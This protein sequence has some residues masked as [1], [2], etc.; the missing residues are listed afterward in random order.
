MIREQSALSYMQKFDPRV[1]LIILFFMVLMVLFINQDHKLIYLLVLSITIALISKE[2]NK[3]HIK[4]LLKLN[5]IMLSIFILV[6]I[7]IE[8]KT[9]FYINDIVW[10]YEGLYRSSIIS[11]KAN[12]IF[13][14][15]NIFVI[16]MPLYELGV[17]LHSLMISKK[18]IH[19]LLFMVRYI[20][21]IDEEYNKLTTA[22]KLRGFIPRPS[23]HTLKVYGQIIGILLIRSFERSEKVYNAMRLRGYN[24]NFYILKKLTIR[25]HDYILIIL[26]LIILVPVFI[27]DVV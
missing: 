24:G 2:F 16:N 14:L 12:I 3:A 21:V 10:S 27:W 19:I 23:I 20:N 17:S 8:G 4:R 6:P 22:I 1:R 15:M 13:F 11:L 26:S 9:F 5:I 25:P 18:L 7:S